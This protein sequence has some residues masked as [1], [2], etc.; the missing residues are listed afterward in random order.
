MQGNFTI[1]N[2]TTYDGRV[3]R[4]QPLRFDAWYEHL[5]KNRPEFNLKDECYVCVIPFRPGDP[6]GLFYVND[7]P[8]VCCDKCI[9]KI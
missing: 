7:V 8:R 6:V 3:P 4:V 1:D 2:G 9:E 5:K